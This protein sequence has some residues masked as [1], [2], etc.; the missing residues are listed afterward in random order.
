MN[1][2]P[3]RITEEARALIQSVQQ[4]LDAGPQVL[5]GLGVDPAKVK[6]MGRALTPAQLKQ[7]EEAV[8]RDLAEID[9]EVAEARARLA[10]QQRSPLTSK[11]PRRFV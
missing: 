9:Q 4:T 8:G 5:R 11:A 10:A 6:A 7:A 1:P 2:T 3:S